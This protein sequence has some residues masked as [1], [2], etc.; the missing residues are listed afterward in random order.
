MANTSSIA[1]EQP[2]PTE[3][4]TATE[5]VR[6][7]LAQIEEVL[8][9][10]VGD[11]EPREVQLPVVT[12][13]W[14]RLGRIERL[15]NSGQVLLA[16][17]VREAEEWQRSGFA[18]AA[19]WMANQS[20]GS[21]GRERSK[22][23]TSERLRDLPNTADELR[24]GGLSSEQAEKITDAAKV[25]PDAEADLI[26]Q[27]KKGSH[28]ELAD[29]AARRKAEAESAERHAKRIRKERS[30]RH[31]VDKDGAMHVHAK[32][33]VADLSEVAAAIDRLVG[34][35]YRDSSL[36]TREGREAYAFDALVELARPSRSAAGDGEH[37]GTKRSTDP[38]HLA[39]IRADLAALV[40]GS[41]DAGEICE[42]AGIG[43]IAVSEA[44]ALLGQSVLKLV[45]TRGVDVMNVTHLGRGPS[46]AQEIA[47][48]WG[49]R[50]CSVEGCGRPVREVDHRIDYSITKRT[51]LDEL[52]GFC[53]HDH[54]LKTY[55]GWA[56]VDGTGVRRFVP[57]GHPDHPGTAEEQ[58]ARKEAARDE[59]HRPDA[60][61][62]GPPGIPGDDGRLFTLTE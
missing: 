22:L 54:D 16:T 41:V 61:P 19:E 28:R 50:F 43:P 9:A 35:R 56:L 17:R 58:F 20:G 33:P 32:G 15:A 24:S 23:E 47:L 39:I 13:V 46:A 44:R 27:A 34:K 18:S 29:E 57:P 52:D 30:L 36:N 40:R 62:V 60:P 49:G 4:C 59:A 10:V 38:T 26:E 42:I 45:I 1:T 31:W 12:E 37:S 14:Q 11:L 5:A 7:A 2:G 55:K 25:N 53:G 8:G 3:E 21:V 6:D 51:R 48:L